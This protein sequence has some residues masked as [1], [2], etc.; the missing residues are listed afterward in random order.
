M[1]YTLDANVVMSCLISGNSKYLTFFAE[2][3]C[4]LPDFGMTEL[5]KYQQVILRK[6]K[7]PPDKFTHFV[8]SIFKLITVV[9]N[10]LISTSQY[11]DA[12]LICRDIDED[13][14][15]YVALTLALNNTLL[16]RD[17]PLADGLRAKGFMNVILID[18]LMSQNDV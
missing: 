9:P 17:K 14:T 8:L 13:D 15:V 12:F 10:M 11:Y 6:S 7:L 16:T 18:E 3:S 5:S 2:N 1:T 4:L